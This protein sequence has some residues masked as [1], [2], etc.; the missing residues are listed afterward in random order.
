MLGQEKE[1]S[2]IREVVQ[3]VLQDVISSFS[4]TADEVLDKPADESAK[5]ESKEPEKK[6]EPKASDDSSEDKKDDKKEDDKMP[7]N[8]LVGCDMAGSTQDANAL[9]S[10]DQS[11]ACPDGTPC[12][13]PQKV[14]AVPKAEVLDPNIGQLG[15]VP[16]VNSAPATTDVNQT[17]GNSAGTTNSEFLDA[18]RSGDPAVSGNVVPE[19]P[20]VSAPATT[21]CPECAG[22]TEI[23]GVMN[24]FGTNINYS[25]NPDGTF[26]VT[27]E[28]NGTTRVSTMQSID[29]PEM[30]L[31][32]EDFL[33]ESY[34]D[35]P[36][37]DPAA[38][39]VA[40]PVSDVPAT[41]GT[42]Q[43]ETIAPSSIQDDPSD[44]A[45]VAAATDAIETTD[46]AP[47]VET[48]LTIKDE[49]KDPFVSS[50]ALSSLRKKYAGKVMEIFNLGLQTKAAIMS[51]SKSKIFAKDAAEYKKKG[52]VLAK[53]VE[54]RKKILDSLTRQYLRARK[55]RDR[56]KDLVSV[57]ANTVQKG[58]KGLAEG[59]L[60]D[61]NSESIVKT[62]QGI[63]S[64]VVTNYGKPNFTAILSACIAQ[65]K[66]VR[67]L[68]ASEIGINKKNAIVAQNKVAERKK[69]LNRRT[70]ARSRSVLGSR[71]NAGGGRQAG[72]LVENSY[73]GRSGTV[74]C[75]SRHDG[76][77]EMIGEISSLI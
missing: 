53:E 66:K 58:Q 7:D 55:E 43:V 4:A 61:Q 67:Y 1:N 17:L 49:E 41:T 37:V 48:D 16:S 68:V 50:A 33:V 46:V 70:D 54:E 8:Q 59:Y 35:V 45:S 14:T 72:V 34:S 26:T 40:D 5:E 47:A 56:I 9:T 64:R 27:F 18:G 24:V 21:G 31:E 23:D 30:M 44:P 42:L 76:T 74:A 10:C 32:L 77:D 3:E 12:A 25:R 11:A 73:I 20:P 38:A 2:Q 22:A 13:E 29:A 75:R 15:S 63:V 28:K 39:P 69:E 57:I 19:E 36:E 60:T 65:S 71:R 6:N 62:L 52:A 51:E